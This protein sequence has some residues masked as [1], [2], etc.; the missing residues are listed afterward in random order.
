MQ[1]LFLCGRMVFKPQ[2][3]AQA[4]DDIYLL[5]LVIS[6]TAYFIEFENAAVG[7]SIKINRSRKRYSSML[8]RQ[9]TAE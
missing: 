5:C 3:F 9:L 6:G 7:T 2:Q 4:S 1:P 8:R